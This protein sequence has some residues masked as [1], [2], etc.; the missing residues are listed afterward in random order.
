[1]DGAQAEAVRQGVPFD[2]FEDERVAFTVSF[3]AVDGADVRMIKGREQVG[4]S[5]EPGNT[6]RIGDGTCLRPSA[7]NLDG[8]IAVEAG[9]AGSIDLAH[10]AHA[11]ALL[12][13]VDAEHEAGERGF[14]SVAF[15]LRH[16]ITVSPTAVEL[17]I[18]SIAMGSRR[19]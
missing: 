6:T 13:L 18:S 19:A 12:H 3:E 7:E 11:Y 8:D 1:M 14:I 4:L 2:Q 10:S 5:A 9:V 17:R 15:D 16:A